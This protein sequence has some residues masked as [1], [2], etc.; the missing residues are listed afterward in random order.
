MR[1]LGYFILVLLVLVGCSN[2]SVEDAFESALSQPNPPITNHKKNLYNY[3]VPKHVGVKNSDVNSTVMIV[4]SYEIL[5][6]LKVDKIVSEKFNY[7]ATQ[8]VETL[9]EPTFTKEANYIGLD[10]ISNKMTMRIYE[11][12]NKSFA[13]FLNNSEVEMVSVVPKTHLNITIETMITIL[14][15][16]KIEKEAIISAYSNKEISSYDGTYS[17]FFEQTPPET[18]TIKDMYERLNPNKE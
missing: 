1:K 13:I 17:E 5:L 14:K 7:E 11:L 10:N 12:K 9:Q 3:Y 4:D 6:N 15:S 2:I 8:P 16:V 18:G